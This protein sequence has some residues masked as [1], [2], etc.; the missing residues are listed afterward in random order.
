MRVVADHVRTALMLLA[1][2]AAAGNEGR[3]YVLRRILRRSVRAM[4]LLGRQD[5]GAARTPACRLCK[6]ME[7]YGVSPIAFRYLC[8]TGPG[9]PFTKVIVFSPGACRILAGPVLPRPVAHQD[10]R[11]LL[12]DCCK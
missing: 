5:P 10:L 6:S 2:G 7:G 11:A 12:R 3:G 4:R 9:M 8:L 1:D